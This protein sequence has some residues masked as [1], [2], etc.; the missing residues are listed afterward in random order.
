MKYYIAENGQ[1]AGP[2]EVDELIAKHGLTVNSMVW[3]DSLTGWTKA[4]EVAELQPALGVSTAFTPA[5]APAQPTPQEETSPYAPEAAPQEVESPYAPNAEAAV[6]EETPYA[7]AEPAAAPQEPVQPAYAQHPVQEAPLQQAAQPQQYAQPQYVQPQVAQP[8]Y[9]QQLAGPNMLPPDTNKVMAVVVIVLSLL[10]CC[11]IVSAVLGIVSLVKGSSAVQ[12]F[13]H[14]DMI[15]A[16][17][18]AKSARNLALAGLVLLIVIPV[19]YTIAMMSMPEFQ[20]AFMQ[21]FNEELG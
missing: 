7:P 9:G 13:S 3:N 6:Q 11:N 8:Q 21:G 5:E 4:G 19:I 15:G 14:G 12:A 17:E 18:Q 1:P 2:F 16:Q 10:C 20:D